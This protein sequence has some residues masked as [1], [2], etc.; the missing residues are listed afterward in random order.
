[1][2]QRPSDEHT[3]GLANECR[4][5]EEG[6]S[7]VEGPFLDFAGAVRALDPASP[8]GRLLTTSTQLG[9]DMDDHDDYLD[10]PRKFFHHPRCPALVGMRVQ[11]AV[12]D[13]GTALSKDFLGCSDC[14]LMIDAG[15]DLLEG[16]YDLV[17]LAN[18]EPLLPYAVDL[19]QARL[20]EYSGGL[21]ALVP[22]ARAGL[23]RSTEFHERVKPHADLVV[24]LAASVNL[25]NE[26]RGTRLGLTHLSLVAEEMRVLGLDPFLLEVVEADYV[27]LFDDDLVLT[28]SLAS[29]LLLEHVTRHRAPGRVLAASVNSISFEDAFDNGPYNYYFAH[30]LEALTLPADRRVGLFPASAAA[31]LA[32]TEADSGVTLLDASCATPEV[33]ETFVVLRRAQDDHTA[34]D[35]ACALAGTSDLERP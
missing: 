33:L 9:F 35:A 7:E 31:A 34:F 17:G 16:F 18:T 4:R 5:D 26:A 3:A 8:L 22:F 14:F 28:R 12:H 30:A 10:P 19:S 23:G 21:E 11:D 24:D 1:M 25:F 2:C 29:A 20:D 32:S 6:W 15:A 27:H 13:L